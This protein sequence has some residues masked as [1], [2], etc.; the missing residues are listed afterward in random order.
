MSLD[1]FV[2]HVLDSYSVLF[3]DSF[4]L[5]A[6]KKGIRARREKPPQ[7]IRPRRGHKI[8]LTSETAIK[9]KHRRRRF[10]I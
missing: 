4:L 7:L 5:A 8:I 9:I 1:S 10:N 3:F 2:T 6:Q